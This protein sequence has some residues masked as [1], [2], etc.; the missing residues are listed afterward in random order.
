MS[1]YT[2]D[3]N[4]NLVGNR[5][6]ADILPTLADGRI[7]WTFTNPNPDFKPTPTG[8]TYTGPAFENPALT[9]AKENPM[10]IAAAA[11]GLLL[12]ALMG[13]RRR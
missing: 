3:E 7:D 1:L 2:I 8:W 13:G 11:A 4:G 12:V 5:T 6:D 9:W 10:I